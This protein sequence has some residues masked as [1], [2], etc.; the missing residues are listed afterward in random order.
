MRVAGDEESRVS[1]ASGALKKDRVHAT[2]KDRGDLKILPTLVI[3]FG[4]ADIHDKN[5]YYT[6][7]L[8]RIQHQNVIFGC[9]CDFKRKGGSSFNFN[10]KNMLCSPKK[11]KAAYIDSN[12]RF[13]LLL[14]RFQSCQSPLNS[15][16]TLHLVRSIIYHVSRGSLPQLPED[17]SIY[18]NRL[19][20]NQVG[21][22]NQGLLK[23]L[24]LAVEEIQKLNIS[25]E[26]TVIEYYCL[27]LVM[28]SH[29]SN[30]DVGPGNKAEVRLLSMILCEY[31]LQNKESRSVPK[32][33]CKRLAQIYGILIWPLITAVLERW[34]VTSE[35]PVANLVNNNLSASN[36]LSLVYGLLSHLRMANETIQTDASGFL[37]CMESVVERFFGQQLSWIEC[38]E[39]RRLLGCHHSDILQEILLEYLK[40]WKESAVNLEKLYLYYNSLL[41]TVEK[42]ISLPELKM[43]LSFKIFAQL[44]WI[45]VTERLRDWTFHL[46]EYSPTSRW[47]VYASSKEHRRYQRR[48]LK[49]LYRSWAESD[50]TFSKRFTNIILAVVTQSILEMDAFEDELSLI[51]LL[52]GLFSGND[53]LNG[54]IEEYLWSGS[55]YRTIPSLFGTIYKRLMLETTSKVLLPWVWSVAVDAL[56]SESVSSNYLVFITNC[57]RKIGNDSSN[58]KAYGGI[59]KA[60]S[61]IDT[62]DPSVYSA[63]LETLAAFNC[64]DELLTVL[65]RGH[66]DHSC[67][68]QQESTMSNLPFGLILGP[69]TLECL[70]LQH[71]QIL[72]QDLSLQG[73]FWSSCLDE[74]TCK[75]LSCILVSDFEMESELEILFD[76]FKASGIYHLLAIGF[77]ELIPPSEPYDILQRLFKSYYESR[78]IFPTELLYQL[79]IPK[80]NFMPLK[81]L[82]GHPFRC[83]GEAA[84]AILAFLYHLEPS[85]RQTIISILDFIYADENIE[86]LKRIRE[87][88]LRYEL[89][90]LTITSMI[91]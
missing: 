26:S 71:L 75:T 16:N 88:V 53:T 61:F 62:T 40:G 60:L 54:I 65:I 45:L 8:P 21:N 36:V 47:I 44:A 74:T 18:L 13:A 63:I 1:I 32:I 56:S 20:R 86:R 72:L 50:A 82:N 69:A 23:W 19:P 67:S 14:D 51:D 79:L 31:L 35:E 41:H 39:P 87:H 34:S 15:D 64:A 24:V 28:A 43:D 37:S 66:F 57:L 4:L 7:Q 6:N 76:F 48:L 38:Y 84:I 85:N 3:W 22:T 78:E 11:C 49:C 70:L 59:L 5:N 90:S 91:L 73:A 2:I 89:T 46:L 52:Q 55:A 12:A 77:L 33:L 58:D 10:S 83:P 25:F 68:L 80:T 9:S 29:K 81:R 27:I 17:I 30:L 42:M